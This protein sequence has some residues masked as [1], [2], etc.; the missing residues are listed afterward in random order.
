MRVGN[1]WPSYGARRS[2]P[3]IGGPVQAGSA[4]TS[5]LSPTTF[6]LRPTERVVNNLWDWD[7]H[8]DDKHVELVPQAPLNSHPIML[9]TRPF[10][11]SRSL[12]VDGY[13]VR[14]D[15]VRN[16]GVN[17]D[18]RITCQGRSV[19]FIWGENRAGRRFRVP[20]ITA[21]SHAV[22][23]I[24]K[25]KAFIMRTH[26]VYVD[27][28]VTENHHGKAPTAAGVSY[29]SRFIRGGKVRH[30]HI[31]QC[32]DRFFV[33]R[34]ALVLPTI[35]NPELLTPA[36]FFDTLLCIGF[37]T[38]LCEPHKQYIDRYGSFKDWKEARGL[39]DVFDRAMTGRMTV[40]ERD[41]AL[42]W[43]QTEAKKR[44]AKF[45]TV[46]PKTT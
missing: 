44:R 35:V 26:E 11:A 15:L 23:S 4:Q 33:L 34:R 24:D 38:I 14:L 25:A 45:R 27:T 1:Y 22:E 9:Y 16:D 3:S 18:G 21:A 46:P 36:A 31:K 29:E 19:N 13:D 20:H 39:S 37:L 10:I 41:M 30:A 28:T 2:A 32:V 43:A 40:E 8:R 7:G 17:F 6:S 12:T 42:A 5:I